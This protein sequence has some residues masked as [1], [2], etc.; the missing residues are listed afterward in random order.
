MVSNVNPS[1]GTQHLRFERDPSGGTTPGCSGI[2]SG[3]GC[4]QNALFGTVD[5]AV[6]P[7]IGPV[8]ISYDI[9]M[10]G[11]LFGFTGSSL[12]LILVDDSGGDSKIPVVLYHHFYGYFFIYDH[13][14]Y[15][16]FRWGGYLG[17][18]GQYNHME[19]QFD[20]CK[21]EV[22]YYIDGQY[23]YRGST[24]GGSDRFNRGSWLFDNRSGTPM[25]W[26]VDNQVINRGAC[27]CG[28]NNAGGPEECDGSD[29]DQCRGRC[30]PPGQPDECTCGPFP[31]CDLAV[32]VGNGSSGPFVSSVGLYRYVADTP[33]TSIDTCGSSFDTVLHW[34]LT[35]NCNVPA[36]T[37]DECND[38]ALP[39]NEALGDPSA[40]CYVQFTEPLGPNDFPMASCLC[41]A[42][43]PGRTYEFYVDQYGGN[44]PPP[45]SS[46]RINIRKKTA[47]GQPI[48]GGACCDPLTAE[49]VD[50]IS[51][52]DC[53]GEFDVYHPNKLCTTPGVACELISGACCNNAP[54]AGAACDS[55]IEADCDYAWTPGVSCSSLNPPCTEVTGTC[56]FRPLSPCGQTIQSACTCDDCVWTLGEACGPQA[57]T[58]IQG[59]CC[60]RDEQSAVCTQTNQAQCNCPDCTWTRE[61]DCADVACNPLFLPIPTV[62]QWG[63]AALAL[64]L[65]IGGKIAR[66]RA[67]NPAE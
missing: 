28:D 16:G 42:T 6:F 64:A 15:Y 3:S 2:S 27:V 48:P 25:S 51:A 10:N 57:C 22:R 4:L 7:T 35:D 18:Y 20:V 44:S 30:V 56:C 66:L 54:G 46:T 62:S 1:H 21:Q 24:I 49:C 34:D 23:V 47:C 36:V 63:L 9:A 5:P 29:D 14:P 50:G 8:T 17:G 41:A 26:D 61:T 33:F 59:A 19:V 45:G 65:L 52:A 38:M 67:R 53:N 13:W 11:P 31:N 37:N 58:P 60:E 39:L 32:P 55:T 40:S 43:E 12:Q